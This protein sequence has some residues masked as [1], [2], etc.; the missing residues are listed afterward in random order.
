MRKMVAVYTAELYAGGIGKNG[1][2]DLPGEFVPS[3]EPPQ[4]IDKPN[5]KDQ[6]CGR[7]QFPYLTPCGPDE[8]AA[9]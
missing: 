4:V 6:G 5:D 9:S 7:H 8:T 3:F 2:T 1:R